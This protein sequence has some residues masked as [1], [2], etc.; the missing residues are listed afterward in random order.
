[1][2]IAT[3]VEAGLS[4]E[5]VRQVLASREFTDAVDADI[6]QAMAYGAR[7]VPFF[8]FDQR[9]GV[10]GAQPVEVFGQVLERAWSAAHPPVEVVAGGEVCGPDTGPDGCPV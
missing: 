7:G 4:E 6:A 10:S 8:V 5:R 9:Y 1:V 2:L 3:A